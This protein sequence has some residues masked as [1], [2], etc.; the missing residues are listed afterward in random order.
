MPPWGWIALAL[1]AA[2]AALAG[3]LLS[4]RREDDETVGTHSP[5]A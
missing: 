4:R 3:W 2:A 5:D 1:L